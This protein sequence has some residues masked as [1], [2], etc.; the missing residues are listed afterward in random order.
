MVVESLRTRSLSTLAHRHTVSTF[1]YCRTTQSDNRTT[2]LLKTD[3][4]RKFIIEGPFSVFKFIQNYS[5]T[6]TA[7]K[8]LL[9]QNLT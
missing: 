1:A 6:P 9:P 8:I 2:S 4:W 3:W 7:S 5:G